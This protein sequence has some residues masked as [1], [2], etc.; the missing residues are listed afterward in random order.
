VRGGYDP[1]TKTVFLSNRL[2]CR[3]PLL[4]NC[5]AEWISERY[6][7]CSISYESYVKL[8][9][10]LAQVLVPLSDFIKLYV[11]DPNMN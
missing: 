6:L 1:I 4:T 9:G 7:V 2:W 11:Y 8:F 10:A 3:K 5:Y